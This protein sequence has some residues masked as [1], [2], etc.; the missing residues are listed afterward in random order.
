MCRWR[1]DGRGWD[2]DTDEE[3]EIEQERRGRWGKERARRKRARKEGPLVV[4]RALGPPLM[5]L[6]VEDVYRWGLPACG[7]FTATAAGLVKSCFTSL[8]VCRSG[9]S[10]QKAGGRTRG[11]ER[12]RERDRRKRG[13]RREIAR[14]REKVIGYIGMSKRMS[15]VTYTTSDLSRSLAVP[16]T[17]CARSRVPGF[18]RPNHIF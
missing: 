14:E 3:R 2:D 16:L 10:W 7:P 4:D 8:P 17:T 9:R 6:S 13:G 18:S 11:G 12:E 15:V 1:W 5:K